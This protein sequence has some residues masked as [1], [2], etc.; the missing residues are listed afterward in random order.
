MRPIYL[1]AFILTWLA[2]IP[3]ILTNNYYL[4][5][6]HNAVEDHVIDV[7]DESE[8]TD[9]AVRAKVQAAEEKAR[10]EVAAA[11]LTD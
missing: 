5:N 9:E 1:L 2:L 7:K 10:R 8:T 6:T 4:G 11:Q 3:G